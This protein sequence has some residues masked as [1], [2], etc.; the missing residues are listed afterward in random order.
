V[1]VAPAVGFA[2]L[3]AAP[4]QHAAAPTLRLSL[5]ARSDAAIRSILLHVQVMIAAR[6][7]A[8]GEED[9]A[10]LFELF[11]APRD[12][13]ATLR[14]L[15]WSRQTLVVPPFQGSTVV[16]LDIPCSYDLEVAAT[17]YFDALPGGEVPL[18]LVFSGALFYVNAAGL[19]QTVRIPWDVEAEYRLPVGVWKETM[20]RHFRGTGWLRL[21]KDVL[22]E[23]HAY[24]SRVA[25]PTWEDAIERLLEER[26]GA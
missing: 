24:R 16:D 2:V 10:P 18:E 21:R 6:R 7:R 5:Q 1:G 13:P 3:G 15:L 25:A 23:L 8:Y 12:W 11:G 22:D 17:R 26:G 19:L 9:H 14:N 20:E 4:V